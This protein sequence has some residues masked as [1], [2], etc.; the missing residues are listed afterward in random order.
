MF[1]TGGGNNDGLYSNAKY[2]ELCAKA[3]TMKAGAERLKVMAQAEEIF[4]TQDQGMIPLYFYV[5]QDLIDTSIWGG[6]FNNP[7]G[8]HP[9][10]YIY[11]K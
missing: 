9:W 8:S 10:K 7:L 11:K 3:V 1:L 5:A 6:W 4:I 2:D